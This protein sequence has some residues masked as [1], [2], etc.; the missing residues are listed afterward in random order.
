MHHYDCN[1]DS[2]WLPNPIWPPKSAKLFKIPKMDENVQ[3]CVFFVLFFILALIPAMS[4]ELIK[5]DG[6]IKRIPFV[7]SLVI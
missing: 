4:L 2:K 1:K 6:E 3:Y 7:S 5:L